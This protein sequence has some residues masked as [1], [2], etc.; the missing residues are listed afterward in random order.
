MADVIYVL[1]WRH[2]VFKAAQGKR[3]L[4][5]SL[6]C[7]ILSQFLLFAL[8]ELGWGS[9]EPDHGLCFLVGFGGTSSAVDLGAKGQVLMPRALISGFDAFTV[10]NN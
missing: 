9:V 5:L 10:P 2:C 6:P 3:K 8:S 7:G 1:G 4:N